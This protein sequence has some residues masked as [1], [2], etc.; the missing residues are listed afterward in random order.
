MKFN[1]G[2]GY[3]S[4]EQVR[5]HF[6]EYRKGILLGEG[7][8]GDQVLNSRNAALVRGLGEVVNGG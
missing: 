8:T 3:K 6:R 2:T 5:S 1:V 4:V 7:K